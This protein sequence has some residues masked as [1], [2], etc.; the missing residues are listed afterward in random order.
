MQD[1]CSFQAERTKTV[2][3]DDFFRKVSAKTIMKGKNI[4][5]LFLPKSSPESFFVEREKFFPLGIMDADIKACS[6]NTSG[7]CS[8]TCEKNKIGT[9]K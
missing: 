1:G 9:K 6:K 2:S 5:E 3:E 8:Q 4:S 7:K